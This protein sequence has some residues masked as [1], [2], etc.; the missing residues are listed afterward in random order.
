ME[1]PLS[2]LKKGRTG[3]VRYLE[4]GRGFQEKV[5]CLGIRIGKQTKV[6]SSQPIGGPLVIEVDNFQVALGRG[7]AEKIF[8]EVK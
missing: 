7:M 5:F 6:V 4:G 1:I 2:K 8:V 3:I